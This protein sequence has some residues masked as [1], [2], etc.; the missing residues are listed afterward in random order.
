[1]GTIEDAEIPV[2]E[3]LDALG[4]PY[5]RFEHPPIATAD[6]AGEHWA[7][8][9]AVHCKN[10]FLRN[11]KGNRH[12]LVI[13]EHTK[14]ADLRRV[15]DQIGDGKLSFASPERLM[16]APRRDAWIGV[17]VRVD[18]RSREAG[19][20]VSRPGPRLGRPHFVSPEH[21]H[22]DDRPR[23][24]RLRAVPA[25]RGAQAAL[26]RGRESA[27]SYLRRGPTAPAAAR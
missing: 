14:R 21:Q 15:A 5:E 18:P 9:H 12:Y 11:Q 1:M 4:I 20:G 17:A 8:I 2:Y 27:I 7:V 13:V 16:R 19:P 22:A 26:H 6:A 10:L 25:R 23:V 3:R 24:C